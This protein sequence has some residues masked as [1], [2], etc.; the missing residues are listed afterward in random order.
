M[1]TRDEYEAAGLLTRIPHSEADRVALLDWLSGLGFSIDEMV[2]AHAV[3]GLQSLATDRLLAPG[4]SISLEEAAAAT[5]TEVDVLRAVMRA[6]G[7]PPDEVRLTEQSLRLFEE[8]AN[9]RALFSD[10]EALHFT[11]VMGASLA[12]IAEA[13]NS[14]FLVDIEG[15][16]KANAPSELALAQQSLLASQSLES[17]SGA[18]GTLFR[19]HMLDATMRSREARRFASDPDLVPLAVGFVDLVGFTPL[20]AAS[21]ARELISL[22]VS[23]ESRAYDIVNDHGGRLV[24]L[25]G[26]EVMFTTIEPAAACAIALDM[27]AALGEEAEV[28][29]RG[30]IAYGDMLAHGGDYY[31]PVVNLAS[32]VADIAVPWEILVTEEVAVRVTGVHELV[33]AG[34]RMLKGFPDPVALSEV[35]R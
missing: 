24:K 4:T 8:F 10:D 35:R 34:R 21:S 28:T 30:G 2:D 9:A 17:V 13:A 14:L 31:G 22:V 27:F 20:T 26:D 29:P 11:R 6:A 15:P 5:H 33:A 19:M 18:I 1:P 3:E 7:F 16:I 12:R 32:R 25:I 23:F